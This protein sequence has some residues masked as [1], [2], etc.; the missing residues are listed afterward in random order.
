LFAAMRL[1][2]GVSSTSGRFAADDGDGDGDEASASA[3]ASRTALS[4]ARVMNALATSE[5]SA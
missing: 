4:S 2:R 5:A 3:A 1:R